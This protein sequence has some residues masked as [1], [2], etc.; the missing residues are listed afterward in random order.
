ME[1]DL[2]IQ[3]LF[4]D[5]HKMKK[6]CSLSYFDWIQHFVRSLKQE[7]SADENDVK[8]TINEFDILFLKI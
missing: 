1:N 6:P 5:V 7:A 8:I 4:T 2:T 3:Y